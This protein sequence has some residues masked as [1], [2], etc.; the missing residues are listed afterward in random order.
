MIR[1]IINLILTIVITC[2]IVA[3]NTSQLEAKTDIFDTG[4]F[5]ENTYYRTLQNW[6]KDYQIINIADITRTPEQN[7][8]NN[9]LIPYYYN[10][11]YEGIVYTPNSGD[12]VIYNINVEKTGLYQLAID[13]Y[14]NTAYTKNP[15][16]SIKVNDKVEYNELTD[17]SLEVL[18]TSI[19]RDEDKRY[20]RY[21]DEL[22]P[23]SESVNKRY[24]SYISDIL[25][26]YDTNYYILLQAGDNKIS[27]TPSC[28]ELLLGNI[29]LGQSK[30][31]ESYN[32][33]FAKLNETEKQYAMKR[34]TIEAENFDYKNDIEIKPSYYKSS[35]MSPN[36]YKNTVLNMLDGTSTSR[37]GSMVTYNINV[38][39]S[40]LYQ[41]TIKYKQNTLN[42]LAVGK[43]IYIDNEIPFKEFQ[44]YLFY[45]TTK[46]VNYT[47]GEDNPYYLYLEKG[48]H[49]IAFESST[50][51]VTDLV[52]RLYQVMDDINSL[53]LTIKSITGNSD[54]TQIDW[55][56]L[57]YLPDI[58]EDLIN[59]ANEINN[60]YEA[61]NEMNTSS[62]KASEVSVLTIAS[63]QL[64]RLAKKP[65]KIQ[66]R[67]A[68][69]CEG[70]GSA[71]QLIGTAIGTLVKE[72]FDID[73]IILHN[74]EDKLKNANGNI[75]SRMWF[76]IKSFFYSF[77]DKR[78]DI[79]NNQEEDTLEIWAA[80][81]MLYNNILQDMVDTEF[82][83]E[84][85]IK[86]RIN[87]LPSSQKIV[88]NN[89]TGTNPD[90]VLSI[91]SWEP[92]NY[93]LRG[94]LEDLSKYD[95]FNKIA[96]NIYGSNFT[97]LIY[98]KGVYGIPETQGMQ[99]LFYRTDILEFLDLEVPNTWDDV[100]KMLPTLQSY[101]MNYYHP[102]G[103]DSA[104]KGF[105]YTSS[106]FYMMGSE[107]FS[108]NGLTTILNTEQSIEAIQYMT[109]LFNIYNLPQ[110]ISSFFEHFRSGSLPIGIADIGFYLQLKYACPE[111]A[112]QWAMTAI[113]GYY[114]D[115]NEIE[116][117]ST[118][119]GKC[120]IMFKSSDMKEEAWEFLKWWHD[121]DTQI[122]YIRNIK[123]YLGEKYLIVPANMDSLINS[124]WD[125]D[126][127]QAVVN[128]AKWSRIPA[129][130]P[131]SYIIEREIANIWNKV[132]ID[133][134][135]VRV[136]VNESIAKVNRELMRKFNEFGY[137]VNDGGKEYVVPVKDNLML[138]VRGR[139]YE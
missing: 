111:L 45:S 113:P 110:Q 137:N 106:F 109:D 9:S 78:Y 95:G 120:S 63:K 91:D 92:Y 47:L 82:T 44:N 64:E 76:S 115:N 17:L 35:A 57:K 74:E 94:M 33:Y 2:S 21:G 112:G 34:I 56:I 70:S 50:E 80:Q 65:N 119:Y 49:T 37:G 13:Y 108:N 105:G 127:K 84:K 22:L 48:L 32:N 6:K 103:S 104:Y 41:I 8:S 24:H 90:I 72:D 89:A 67:L 122:E 85:N 28:E 123:M 135:N 114:N 25:S 10:S 126:V 71:Y 77:F 31:I 117:W 18:W 19:K 40:G 36:N 130:T 134:E 121:T 88:L 51:H 75:F 55:N 98:D 52:N 53:G 27:I 15:Q 132:V 46:W 39:E 99:L 128:Q 96:S 93:A 61:I 81:S 136:A 101:Q 107:L 69:L 14:Y 133:K 12:E 11:Q 79:T 131:G 4:E 100:L 87:V 125:N 43:N 5:R 68:E 30:E 138:W 20:N 26:G 86:V 59:Y 73:Y 97:T 7:L 116:R 54:D 102:L 23:Y 66:N 29:T 3:L 139:E 118:T 129:I 16:I 58:Q 60:I 62:N 83:K 42:G 1:K 124:V 38:E